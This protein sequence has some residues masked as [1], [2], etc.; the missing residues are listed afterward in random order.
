[1]SSGCYVIIAKYKM[2]VDANN[3]DLQN[4]ECQKTSLYIVTRGVQRRANKA[5]ARAF[6]AGG[7]QRVQLQ[8]VHFFKIFLVGY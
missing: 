3:Y 1:L 6:K 7:I 2:L 8:K 5:T 4:V